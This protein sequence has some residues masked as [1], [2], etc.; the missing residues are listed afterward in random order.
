MSYIERVWEKVSQR[1]A[2]EVEFLQAVRE[3]LDDR[4]PHL[5]LRARLGLDAHVLLDQPRDLGEALG[6]PNS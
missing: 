2:G 6:T 1:N 3:V 5:A 4:R